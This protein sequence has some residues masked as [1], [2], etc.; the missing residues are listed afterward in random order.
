MLAA[1]LKRTFAVKNSKAIARV[2]LDTDDHAFTGY[3][4]WE[5]NKGWALASGGNGDPQ[6]FRDSSQFLAQLR[7]R[8]AK[9]PA[10]LRSSI[11]Y[12]YYLAQRDLFV[13]V[14]Q[15]LIAQVRQ[16]VA[17]GKSTEEIM[18]KLHLLGDQLGPVLKQGLK[19]AREMWKF[20]RYPKPV[21]PNEAILAHDMKQLQQLREWIRAIDKDEQSAFTA[22]PL[23]GRWQC[24]YEVRNTHPGVL[25]IDLSQ[26][27]GSKWEVIKS[28]HTIEFISTAARRRNGPTHIY[29]APIDCDATS[30]PIELKLSTHGTGI[31]TIADLTLTNGVTTHNLSGRK[32]LTL[33]GLQTPDQWA[34]IDATTEFTFSVG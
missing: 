26:K 7:Q 8:A 10:V 4:R 34:I 29:A 17:A 22:N 32:L 23:M 9:W 27:V 18:V 31:V 25:R 2:L 28:C 1:G 11:D 24:S 14:G 16:H 13:R 6:P 20:S 12:R 33:G 21:G 30:G 3:P 15:S 19:A 5:I